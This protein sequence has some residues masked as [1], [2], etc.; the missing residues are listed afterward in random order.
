MKQQEERVK[1]VEVKRMCKNCKFC[2]EL[3]KVSHPTIKGLYKLGCTKHEWI[4]NWMSNGKSNEHCFCA[5]FS[6]RTNNEQLALF[7]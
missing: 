6:E 7:G 5:Y 3:E 4:T 2:K 1:E